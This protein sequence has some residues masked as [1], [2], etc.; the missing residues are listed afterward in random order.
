MLYKKGLKERLDS[1]VEFWKVYVK[2]DII[3][4]FYL[5]GHAANVG[6][7]FLLESRKMAIKF[8]KILLIHKILQRITL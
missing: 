1:L 5:G 8:A 4:L 7:T 6:N 3:F 2:K